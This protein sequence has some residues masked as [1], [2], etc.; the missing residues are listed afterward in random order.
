M[1][2]YWGA[3]GY[4]RRACGRLITQGRPSTI[5]KWDKTLATVRMLKKYNIRKRKRAKRKAA[6]T[7]K[8]GS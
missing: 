8:E 6:K 1:P 3:T 7:P 5:D 4:V 2:P